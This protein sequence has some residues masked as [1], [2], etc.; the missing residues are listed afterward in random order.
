MLG[1]RVLFVLLIWSAPY[2]RESW[3]KNVSFLAFQLW[4]TC[5]L[6]L[7]SSRLFTSDT[8]NIEQSELFTLWLIA[9]TSFCCRWEDQLPK[10]KPLN[11]PHRHHV[12]SVSCAGGRDDCLQSIFPHTHF[13]SFSPPSRWG[14]HDLLLFYFQCRR[15]LWPS[16]ENR[17]ML[18]LWTRTRRKQL[19]ITRS[20]WI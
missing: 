10:H 14:F 17:L 16:S 1:R 15:R 11:F 20:V 3:R 5:F 18:Q 8:E 12:R 4:T 9:F 13:S 2:K 6:P 19:K 7:S